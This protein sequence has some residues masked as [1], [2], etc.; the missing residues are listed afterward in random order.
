MEGSAFLARREFLISLCENDFTLAVALMSPLA[1]PDC[2]AFFKSSILWEKY[3]SPQPPPFRSSVEY[4]YRLRPGPAGWPT[5][6]ML[7]HARH[8]RRRQRMALHAPTQNLHQLG[9]NVWQ[10]EKAILRGKLSV[11]LVRPSS[12]QEPC[13]DATGNIFLTQIET[14]LGLRACTTQDGVILSVLWREGKVGKKKLW[15]CVAQSVVDQQVRLLEKDLMGEKVGDKND[16]FLMRYGFYHNADVWLKCLQLF[17]RN[18]DLG[19]SQEALD[20]FD[21]W[22]GGNNLGGNNLTVNDLHRNRRY[23]WPQTFVNILR[24]HVIMQSRSTS[25]AMLTYSMLSEAALSLLFNAILS[26]MGSQFTQEFIADLTCLFL[27]QTAPFSIKSSKS[28][29][30]IL[31]ALMFRTYFPNIFSDS[32]QNSYAHCRRIHLKF[33]RLIH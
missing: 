15:P 11:Q 5:F 31:R 19:W 4:P 29:L 25:A 32:A 22:S 18:E 17:A 12:Q 27:S 8:E 20:K 3:T 14:Y 24:E 2:E 26:V 6:V 28:V 23:N 30:K 10:I 9:S 1:K 16:L 33:A 21:R 13:L 7:L